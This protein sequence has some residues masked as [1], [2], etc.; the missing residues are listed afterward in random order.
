MHDV[1]KHCPGFGHCI[2]SIYQRGLV[3]RGGVGVAMDG[4]GCALCGVGLGEEERGLW[5]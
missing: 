2:R 4:R 1:S 5:E 3:F